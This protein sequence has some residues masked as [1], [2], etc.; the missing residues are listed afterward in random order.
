[1]NDERS[2]ELTLKLRP[3]TAI[4]RLILYKPKQHSGKVEC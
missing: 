4:I 3:R 1:M 2:S